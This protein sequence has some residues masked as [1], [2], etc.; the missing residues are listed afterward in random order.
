MKDHCPHRVA[1]NVCKLSC[2]LDLRSDVENKCAIFACPRR[3]SAIR[4][5]P[6]FLSVSRRRRAWACVGGEAEADSDTEVAAPVQ[7]AHRGETGLCCRDAGRRVRRGPGPPRL[8]RGAGS[9][10]LL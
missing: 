4:A 9:L 8:R 10:L 2:S 5:P 1:N 3:S 7:P 6:E